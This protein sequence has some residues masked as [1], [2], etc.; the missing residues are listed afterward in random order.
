MSAYSRG[1]RQGRKVAREGRD[2]PWMD[3][4]TNRRAAKSAGMV[5]GH[6]DERQEF[7]RRTEN[8]LGRERMGYSDWVRLGQVHED[9]YARIAALEAATKKKAKP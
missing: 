8:V 2:L 4:S 6:E 5:R 7:R 1:Y 3:V 9:I